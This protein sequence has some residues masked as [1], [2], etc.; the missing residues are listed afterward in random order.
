MGFH[1]YLYIPNLHRMDWVYKD[2][3]VRGQKLQRGLKRIRFKYDTTL[4][5]Y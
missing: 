5:L 2:L 3:L 1:H 4:G